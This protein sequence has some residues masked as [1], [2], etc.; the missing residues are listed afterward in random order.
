MSSLKL[1]RVSACL[2]GMGLGCS[3]GCTGGSLPPW[4]NDSDTSEEGD[5]DEPVR[6]LDASIQQPQVSSDAATR[7]D[8][9]KP[10]AADSG[11]FE[12]AG[13]TWTKPA[14]RATC[15]NGDMT[16]G[17]VAGLDG[18]FRCNLELVGKVAAPHF[19]S[20]AWYEDCAYVNGPDG[21]TVVKVSKDGTPTVTTTLTEVGARSNW[22][23]M[24]A[25]AVSGLLAGY[26]SNG[27]TLVV[28]D[29]SQDC[30]KPK[31][32]SSTSLS[33]AGTSSSGHAG[34]FSPDGTI[35]YASSL[36]TSE[37]FAVDLA[38]P[39]SPK[40]ITSDFERGTHDVFVGKGGTRAYFARSVPAIGTL[41]IMDVSEVQERK[42]NAKGKLIHEFTWVDG[43]VSQYPIPVSYR[44]V[45]HLIV[46]DELGA[47]TCDLPDR[48]QWGY[49][50]IF[51]ISEEKA[52]K[53]VSLV[54][55]EAQDPSTCKAPGQPLIFGLGFFGVGT[56][57]CNVDRLDDPRLLAC[58]NWEGGLRVYDI[59]NPWRPREVGYF[60]APGEGM[61]G[62]ARIYTEKQE[63]WLAT[64]PGTFYVFKFPVGSPIHE[65]L[66]STDD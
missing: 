37:V 13:Q 28:Y 50:H 15:A 19:L 53:T 61:P 29:V 38:L 63:L 65:I 39:E 56:H 35:Y 26:E 11:Q 52:P 41:A 4:D 48:P 17:K 3:T 2:L 51:D 22:E 59:R 20:V 47:G 5:D 8:A 1:W 32:K 27:S 14:P 55:T 33:K 9:T 57:Y 58:G 45:D 24:K 21:T 44:G 66:A 6:N 34:S 54:K 30:S 64:T 23:S 62:L 12:G 7:P 60:D 31:L 36:S 40:V 42:P 16:D 25:S 18:A 49:A 46:T 10:G 43:S